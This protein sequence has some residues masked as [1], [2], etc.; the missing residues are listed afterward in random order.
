M[1]PERENNIVDLLDRCLNKGIILNAD[2]IIS[3]AGV[4]LI[5]ISLKA[6]IASI[7]TMLDYGMM[8][9]WDER[10]RVWCAAESTKKEA[11]LADGEEILIRKSGS[12]WYSQGIIQSWRPGV[13]YLTNKRLFLWNGEMFFETHLNRVKALTFETETYLENNEQDILIL[14][15]NG[16][17]IHIR[18]PDVIGFREAIEKVSL[19][20]LEMEIP[21]V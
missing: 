6:A 1:D 11:V 18:V 16:E 3:V 8:E 2:V 9:A 14:H 4:P 13:W 5:G 10:T 21:V 7:E 12:I 15:I 17:P 20:K 19:K